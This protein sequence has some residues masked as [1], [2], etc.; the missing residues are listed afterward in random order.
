MAAPVVGFEASDLFAMGANFHEK[1]SSSIDMDDASN[2]M[3][4]SG[5]I[6]C[7]TMINGRVEYTQEA[8]YCNGTPDI[9]TDLSTLLT[10]CLD[11]H[12]SKKMDSLTINFTAGAYASVSIAGHQHDANAHASGTT[13]GYFDGSNALPSGA[14]FGV[15]TWT[16]QVDG[17]NATAVSAT[18][19]FSGNHVDE[20][21]AAGGHFVGKTITPQVTLTVE[22][23]GVPTT[24]TPT[25][26]TQDSYGPA[27]ANSGF[28]RST[29]TGHYNFDLAT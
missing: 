1:G 28:D 26:W 22:W 21:A 25:N 17:D 6:E 12:D 11:V 19:T 18:I 9:K 7:E 20:I 29:W 15:P 16:G 10:K 2:M 14:G 4:K 3:D 23:I 24:P 8:D 27:D 5:N 13:D